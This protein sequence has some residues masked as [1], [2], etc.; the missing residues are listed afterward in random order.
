[1]PGLVAVIVNFSSVSSTLDLKLLSSLTTLW[2]ISSLFVHVTS[3]PA[4]TVIVGGVKLK[5]S[6]LISTAVGCPATTGCSIIGTTVNINAIIGIANA[7]IQLS[8]LIIFSRDLKYFVFVRD[9]FER[10]ISKRQRMA[11]AD[12]VHVCHSQQAA[13]LFRWN[14]HRS[15]RRRRAW[16]RLREGRGSCR[17]KRDVPFHL[18]HGLMNVPVK[19]R[20][21]SE[22]LEIRER[23]RA[24]FGTPTP[25]RIYRP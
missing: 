25:L 22:W 9:L 6:I 21:R 24:V 16:M 13:Q 11:F 15:R 7:K 3:V 12:I 5:L 20:Y 17:V 18:L 2:G 8:F 10:G 4:F 23:L 14:L 1:M 19:H